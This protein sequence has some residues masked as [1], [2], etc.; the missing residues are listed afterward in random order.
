MSA[1]IEVL[2]ANCIAQYKRLIEVSEKAGAK[3][4]TMADMYQFINNVNS[5]TD[6]AYLKNMFNDMVAE[7]DRIFSEMSI[8]NSEPTPEVVVREKGYDDDNPNLAK[9]M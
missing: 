6:A 7:E 5:I 9:F 3:P 8:K 2:R 1:D 4:T